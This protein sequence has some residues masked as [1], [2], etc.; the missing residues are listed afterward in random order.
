MQ[1]R[2]QH[3]VECA[4][5]RSFSCKL[6]RTVLLEKWTMNISVFAAPWWGG[7]CRMAL[8]GSWS[9]SQVRSKCHMLRMGPLV[10]CWGL[11]LRTEAEQPRRRTEG[12]C[13]VVQG[14]AWPEVTS[15]PQCKLGMTSQSCSPAFCW[16]TRETGLADLGHNW[17]SGCFHISCSAQILSNQPHG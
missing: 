4:W 17:F 15:C 9:C 3:S 13:L 16:D 6:F 14:K 10:L 5:I 2:G 7:R 1:L 11:L 12:S 8:I